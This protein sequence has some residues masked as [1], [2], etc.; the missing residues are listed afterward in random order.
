M[1][2]LTAYDLIR[3]SD[4]ELGALFRTFNQA[5]ARTRPFTKDW[6]DAVF[7][8]DKILCERSRRADQMPR[9]RR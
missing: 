2:I 4:D 6:S 3:R 7:A 5:V 8:V 1:T 9:P